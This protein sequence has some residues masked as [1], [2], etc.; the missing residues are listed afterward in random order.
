MPP[1]PPSPVTNSH[2]ASIGVT[3]GS[4]VSGSFSAH[5]EA[6]RHHHGIDPR[7]RPLRTLG[8]LAGARG[9]PADVHP[10][11]AGEARMA[12]RL[13]DRRIGVVE[14][15]V[16]AD[17]RHLQ[18]VRGVVDPLAQRLATAAEH[19]GRRLFTHVSTICTDPWAMRLSASIAP[20]S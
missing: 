20:V 11:V 6:A 16:L 17:Q 8:R 2:C 18:T 1:G 15:D 19:G 12:D 7:Q 5:A 14:I 13:G 4:G 10:G 9:D 3:T